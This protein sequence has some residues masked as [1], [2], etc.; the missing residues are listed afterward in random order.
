MPKTIGAILSKLDVEPSA[1][2]AAAHVAT[3]TKARLR[4]RPKRRSGSASSARRA[5]ST[6]DG[7]LFWGNDRLE[8]RARLGEAATA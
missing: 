2:L 7:E 5:S 4:A 8:Q 3:T 1:V 6:A